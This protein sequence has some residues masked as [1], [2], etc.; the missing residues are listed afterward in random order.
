MSI[1]LDVKIYCKENTPIFVYDKKEIKTLNKDIIVQ[2]D[3]NYKLDNADIFVAFL[4]RLD[5]RLSSKDD[6]I[7]SLII[8]HRSNI[9]NATFLRYFNGNYYIGNFVGV[10]KDSIEYEYSGKDKKETLNLIIKLEIATRFDYRDKK[11]FKP[12]FLCA[13]LQ[14]GEILSNDDNLKSSDETMF[15]FLLLQLFKSELKKVMKL[16]YYQT[17][18]EFKENND[19]FRGQLDVPR[20]IKENSFYNNGDI[21]YKYR[22]KSKNN[23]FNH[24]IIESY[25]CLKR[26]Y[27]SLTVS[28]IDND[29]D[30]HSYIYAL[31]NSIN[32]IHY[33]LKT[34]INNNI[35]PIFH[36]YYFP[37]ERLRKVCLKILRNEGISIF[38]ANEDDSL[39]GI[40]YYVPDLWE[41]FLE[42]NLKLNKFDYSCSNQEDKNIFDNND[43]NYRQKIRPDFVIRKSE[44]PYAILD[45]KFVE[46]WKASLT[47]QDNPLQDVFDDF[48]KCIRDMVSFG[49]NKGGVIF[50]VLKLDDNLSYVHNIFNNSEYKFYTFC[51]KIPDSK[52]EKEYQK[53]N[54]KFKKYIKELQT[55][56]DNYLLEIK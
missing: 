8:S 16:G 7:K 50:P 36:P 15:D 1:E 46:G 20:Y 5:N 9:N 54:I 23:Y 10:V 11:Y 55:N 45:A 2:Y 32:N 53:W 13:L 41:Q 4:S 24:L 25:H 48:N 34:I 19:R 38:D 22:E 47:N 31:E 33:S 51:L 27:Y 12:Y 52:E 42:N 14:S 37:Y 28:A 17:Y 26:K 21:S 3:D 35:N 6:K 43:M 44:T 29:Y 56:L 30:I 40:I 18:H 39:D 49:V